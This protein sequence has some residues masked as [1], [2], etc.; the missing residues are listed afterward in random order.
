MQYR[1]LEKLLFK[2]LFLTLLPL[3]SHVHAA[4]FDVSDEIELQSALNAASSNGESDIINV[5]PG[6]YDGSV[7]DAGFRFEP[8]DQQDLVISG[9]PENNTIIDGNDMVTGLSV[10]LVSESSDSEIV[11][12]NITF[13]N[14]NGNRAG[15][16]LADV[17]LADIVVESC[18]FES[19]TS[20]QQG[21][22]LP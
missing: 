1:A 13:R 17:N 5:S 14:G 4:E 11:V 10:N 21:G 20:Q 8:G 18:V 2:L 6:V 19:N 15:G 7:F 22:G 3:V 16:L 9:D 12:R